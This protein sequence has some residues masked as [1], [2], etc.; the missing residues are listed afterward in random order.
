MTSN[1]DPRAIRVTQLC[2]ESV[3]QVGN[4]SFSNVKDTD[5]V[6]R[7]ESRRLGA[8]GSYLPL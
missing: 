7:I 4:H 1:V 6:S 3:A 8:K 2:N 5:Y